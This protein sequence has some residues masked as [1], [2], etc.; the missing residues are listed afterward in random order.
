MPAVTSDPRPIP[1]ARIVVPAEDRAEITA[2]IDEALATGALTLGR[3]TQAFEAAFARRHAAPTGELHAVAVASGTAAL[4]IVL[5]SLGDPVHGLRGGEVV[6]PTNTFY[7]TAG[8]VVHAGGVPRFADVSAK[9]L[10]LSAATVE[11]ALS[12]HTV[13]VIV[14]HIGGLVTPEIVA[15]RQLCDRRGIWLFEDAAHAHGSRY[16]GRSAGTFGVAGAFSFYPTKV[17][18]SGEGGMILT[19]DDR[20]AEDARIYR[21]QGKAGFLGGDHVRMGYAW[22]MSELHAAVGVSQMKRLDAFIAVRQRVAGRYDKALDSLDGIDA[23]AV[24]DACAMNYYKYIAMLDPTID[25]DALK[26]VLREEYEVSLSGEVYALPLHR[27]PVLAEYAMGALPVADEMCARHVCLPIF[28]DMTDQQADR[29]CYALDR[30][31]R[32]PRVRR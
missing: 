10:A 6:V 17:I 11:A 26:Q 12:D 32:S 29:V 23:L 7:A 24:P 28:S 16:D 2:W 15:I 31:L 8:A 9:T 3:H 13:G 25:R 18:T 21:D 20:L 5:R 19:G 4:E 22:R 14:V 1:A 27:Q 30:A